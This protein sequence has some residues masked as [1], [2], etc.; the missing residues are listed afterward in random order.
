MGLL[1]VP[2]AGVRNWGEHLRADL[3]DLL[4]QFQELFCCQEGTSQHPIPGFHRPF[5]SE[6][7][8]QL[9]AAAHARATLRGRKSLAPLDLLVAFFTTRTI[10]SEV[11]ERIGICAGHLVDLAALAEQEIGRLP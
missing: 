1:A 6:Q 5:L 2:D 10:V 3:P 9:L 8:V 11:F 7:V 4:R